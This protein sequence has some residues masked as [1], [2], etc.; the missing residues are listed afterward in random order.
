MFCFELYFIVQPY[1]NN[2][3]GSFGEKDIAQL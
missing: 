1:N 3:K 2:P